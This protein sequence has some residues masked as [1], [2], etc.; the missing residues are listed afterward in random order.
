[1]RARNLRKKPGP[2][3]DI[4]S[5]FF[6]TMSLRDMFPQAQGDTGR[7]QYIDS[8]RLRLIWLSW[9]RLAMLVVLA[10]STLLFSRD[11]VGT[12]LDSI[13]G[14]LLWFTVVCIVPASLYFPVLLVVRSQTVLRSVAVIQIIQDSAFAAVMVV[15]TGGSSSGF[16]FFFPLMIIIAGLVLPRVGSIIGVLISALFLLIIAVWEAGLAVAPDPIAPIIIQNSA[17]DLVYTYV[18]NLIAFV[19]VAVLSSF[20]VSQVQK[21]DIQRDRY[22]ENLEDLRVLHETILSSLDTG[23][24]TLSLENEI[25]HLNRAAEEL[26]GVSLKAVK[27]LPLRQILPEFAHPIEEVEGDVDVRRLTA[28]AEEQYL[29]IAVKPLL[30]SAWEMVGRLIRIQDVTEIRRMEMQRK[31]DERLATIGKMSAVIAHEIR[32]PLAAIS[33]SAQMVSM[34]REV[35]GD[36]KLALDIVVRE[37]DHLNG[38]ISDLL[39]Y[40]RPRKDVVTA[41]EVESPLRQAIH[42]AQ[43]L[44]E[45]AGIVFLTDLMPGLIMRGDTLRFSRVAVN[46]VKNA[47]EAVAGEG[48]IE[49]RSF[50][51]DAADGKH[52]VVTFKNDGPIIPPADLA[53]I[54]D[55]FFTTKARGTGLGLASAVQYCEDFGGTVSAISNES[56][57]TIFRIDIP[58]RS[59]V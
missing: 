1:M 29:L 35:N 47:V 49:I 17:E 7:S 26:L 55:V 44:P 25:L 38:W 13:R 2:L 54:F 4:A 33:A 6:H 9:V 22:R 36:D 56:E 58:L 31:S 46:I 57:G 28:G 12:L 27:G 5:R 40:A 16:T 14:F 32:N 37:T 15:A 41:F 8:F 42:M 45:A 52:V 53:R 20:L 11:S 3:A 18:I 24:V 51:E 39:E 10:V 34:S 48:T 21:S 59:D 43:A 19:V 30:S 50:A 23:L